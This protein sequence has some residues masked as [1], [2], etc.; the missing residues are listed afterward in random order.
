MVETAS[1]RIAVGLAAY[2][3]VAYLTPQ[4][5]S[6]L[7]QTGVAVT[8]FVS[9]DPST[10]GTEAWFQQQAAT[11][12]RL[13]LLPPA[14]RFGC[15]AAN[16]LRLLREVD[17]QGFDAFC[18]ADQDDIWAADKLAHAC[19]RMAESGAQGYSSNVTAFWP[20]GR[21]QLIDKAQPQR[22]WDHLFEAAGPGC[23]YVLAAE[24]AVALQQ[25]V[26]ARQQELVPLN[27]HDWFVYAFARIHGHR[28]L[29]D[30]RPGVSYR[31]H[32]GN[33]VGA[34][35]GLRAFLRRAAKVRNGEALSQARLIARVAGLAADHTVMRLLQ[36]GR[37]GVFGLAFKARHCR[38]RRV[39]QVYFFFSCLLTALVGTQS[40]ARP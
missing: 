8:V 20:D 23:T 3:G 4:L 13:H 25:V 16:F 32:T 27:Y 17:L 28:W 34:N 30:P 33:Q 26:R 38:R 24:L 19:L 18:F 29:I 14:G 7:G 2:N 37:G 6:I 40:E 10:D 9:V 36:Q 31:Q 35:T 15:A 1:P 21:Q 39:E 11:E 5:A 22:R 12:P